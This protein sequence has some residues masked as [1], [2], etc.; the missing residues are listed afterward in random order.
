MEWTPEAIKA[1]VDRRHEDARNRALIR[2]LRESRGP[3]PSW[4]R[5]LRSHVDHDDGDREVRA[6]AA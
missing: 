5:R 3:R 6:R 4:W 2:E 1:E